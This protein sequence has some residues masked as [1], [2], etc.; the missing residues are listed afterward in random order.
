MELSDFFTW[1]LLIG[2]L[3]VFGV[4]IMVYAYQGKG[5]LSVL[6]EQ[7]LSLSAT[8]PDSDSGTEAAVQFQ[9]GYNAYQAGQY[10]QAVEYFTQAITQESSFA[11]AYHNRGLAYANLRQDDDSV[12]SLLAASE[13]Y[14]QQNNRDG[15]LLL[16]QH[17]AAIKERKLARE[18]KVS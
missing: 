16:K 6:F 13:L 7:P 14:N 11:Q 17:L 10:R 2:S 9:A 15:L 5:S 8:L 12:I 4:G 3:A 18:N 1:L